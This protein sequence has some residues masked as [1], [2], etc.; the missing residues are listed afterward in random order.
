M[1]NTE[2]SWNGEFGRS[3][4][5][6]N[7][8]SPSELDTLYIKIFGFTRTQ[9]NTE[10]IGDM[11]RDIRILEV[12][13]NV[14]NQLLLLQNIGFTNL[15]GIEVSEYAVEL[16]KQRSKGINVIKASA[17]DIPFKDD[18]FDLVFTSG[19]L[20]HIHPN[21]LPQAMAEMYRVAR[22]YI[23]CQEYFAEN[24]IEIEYR[25]Q[26]NLLWKNDFMSLFLDHYHGLKVVKEK[27][28]K[29]ITDGNINQAFLL[30][31]DGGFP[32]MSAAK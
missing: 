4:T 26:K 14:C 3:Y 6:R 1:A 20:I 17:L 9:L 12:G 19:V 2:K 28:L 16:S 30:K 27:K 11:D 31:K 18:Y 8:L 7:I 21:D 5:D 32:G 10:F 13:S 23:W 22:L 24:N 25:G 29:Y 15:W